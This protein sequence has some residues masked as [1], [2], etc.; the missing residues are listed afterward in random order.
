MS[1]N[2]QI[3][4][5]VGF[6]G[7]FGSILRFYAVLYVQKMEFGSFPF[8]ILFVNIFG[9][10]L[11]G[12][13]YAYFSTNDVSS[14]LKAFLIA[15]F[16]GGLTTFSTFALDS[17]LLFNSSLNFAILNILSN[18]FGSIFFVLIGFKLTIFIIKLF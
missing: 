6:G 3:A 7:A 17:Y 11:I 1:L 14:I 5:A 2:W 8:G 18:L 9:S 15:G 12:I 10:F 4:L 16:L 13:F